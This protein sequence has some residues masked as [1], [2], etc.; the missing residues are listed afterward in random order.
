MPE[1]MSD[2]EAFASRRMLSRTDEEL[3]LPAPIRCRRLP[4]RLLFSDEK[5]ADAA[6]QSSDAQ[7]KLHNLKKM[8]I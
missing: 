3:E 6:E 7:W 1:L 5:M 4:T 8:G 2:A